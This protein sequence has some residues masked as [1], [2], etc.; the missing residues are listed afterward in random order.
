VLDLNTN[1]QPKREKIVLEKDSDFGRLKREV[2][3][4]IENIEV[5]FNETVSGKA[6]TKHSKSPALAKREELLRKAKNS[7][8]RKMVGGGGGGGGEREIELIKD[9]ELMKQR[10]LSDPLLRGES[11]EKKPDST[12]VNS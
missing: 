6:A 9:K 10:I 3:R 7:V 12:E 5:R 4:E 2:V 11:E 8:M 1:Y